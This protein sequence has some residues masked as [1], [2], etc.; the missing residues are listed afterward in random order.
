METF[1]LAAHKRMECF[2]ELQCIYGSEN[3]SNSER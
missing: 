3:M 2:V 1:Y